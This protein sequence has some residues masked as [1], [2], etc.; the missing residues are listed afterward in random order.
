MNRVVIT[1]A[2]GITALGADWSSVSSA[3]HAGRNAVRYMA[4]WE[5]IGGLRSRL[6]SPVTDFALPDH[7]PRRQRRSMG[8]VAAMAVRSA[9]RAL[10]DAGLLGEPLL[11]SGAV[12]I[13]YGSATGS[14]DAL[15]EF[16]GTLVDNDTRGLNATSYV[17]M[18]SHTAAVNIGIVFGIKG[19]VI[20]TSSACTAGSQGIGYAFETIRHGLQEVMIA[21]GAEELSPTEVAVFDTL[22]ATS[23]RND[24][25][26]STPRPFDAQR[27]GLVIGE[28]AA[29]LILESRAHAI[30]RGARVLGEIVGFGTNSDGAHITNPD[31]PTQARCMQLALAS[32]GLGA[33]AIGYVNAHGTATA[34]GDVSESQAT[35]AVF[36]AV[37]ISSLK[38]YFGHTLGACGAQEAWMT[39]MM[40][41]DGWF[42]PTINLERVDPQC[43]ELDYIVGDG[44]TLACEYAMSNNFAF[45]GINTSLI[46][47]RV[48]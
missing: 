9:E 42:A 39:M 25:A 12:G 37:P 10:T 20:P 13:A 29:T 48:N 26:A 35:A 14:P 32:C 15:L 28:G 31:A 5:G 43:A 40:M 22:L 16:V 7:Y 2:A 3:L 1:G 21:G 19:R 30:A 34:A 41:R 17:R 47:R 23:M 18:M 36:G 24:A 33:D 46:L 6:A 11:G 27:D 8:R 4:E 45:G 44:R 38:S